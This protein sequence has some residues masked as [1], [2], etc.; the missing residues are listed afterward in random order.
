MLFRN[1]TLYGDA[2]TARCI[3]LPSDT[4]EEPKQSR[5]SKS[6]N[7]VFQILNPAI[8]IEKPTAENVEN[9]WDLC[10]LLRTAAG[11]DSSIE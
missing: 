4:A 10:Q 5:F 1:R 7:H 6:L 9:W 3:L 2:T 11:Y 8:Q